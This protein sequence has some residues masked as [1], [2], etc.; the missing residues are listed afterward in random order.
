VE[1]MQREIPILADTKPPEWVSAVL[2]DRCHSEGDA[3]LLCWN[4][5]RVKYSLNEAAR[6]MGLPVSHLSNILSGKKYLPNGFR[7]VF[8]RL[9]GNW[10]IRQYEDKTEGFKTVVE[11]PDQQRIRVL[12]AQLADARRVA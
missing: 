7:G 4:K 5:R 9:C 10:S 1:K 12:E 3:I 2:V 11:S 8:Q 6:L